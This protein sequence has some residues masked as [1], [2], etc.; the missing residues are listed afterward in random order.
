MSVG[1]SVGRSVRPSV[2]C[3]YVCMYICHLSVL[4]VWLF[5]AFYLCLHDTD[6]VKKRLSI[7]RIP[8]F[9]SV[10]QSIYPCIYPPIFLSF[11]IHNRPLIFPVFTSLLIFSYIFSRR[12][13]LPKLITLSQLSTTTKQLLSSKVIYNQ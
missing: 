5:H 11:T 3:M 13:L 10:N 12:C 9:L 4:S 6:I 1:R 7:H 2:L 8:F